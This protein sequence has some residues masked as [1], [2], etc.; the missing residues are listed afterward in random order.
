MATSFSAAALGAEGLAA[1]V[2]HAGRQRLRARPRRLRARP[3]ARATPGVRA[4]FEGRLEAEHAGP[5]DALLLPRRP[6]LHARPTR[7]P[8][9]CSSTDGTI[10][11]LGG[12]DAA[13]AHADGADRGGRPRRR[14]GDPGVRRRPRAPDRRPGS[15]CT[16]STSPAAPSLAEA[17]DAVERRGPRHRRR[18]SLLGHGW[19]ETRWPE[20]PAAHRA[21]SST[22]PPY[23]RRGLPV[24]RRRALRGGLLGARSPPARVRGSRRAATRRGLVAAGGPPRGPRRRS[25]RPSPRPSDGRHRTGRL[26]PRAAAGHRRWSTRAAARTSA[27]PRTSPTCSR[28]AARRAPARGRRLLGRARRRRAR[29]ASRGALG[30]PGRRRPRT[31]TAR[32]ARAP[33]TCATP[34]ADA[35]GRCGHGYLERRA[36][37]RPRR[38]LHAAGL[39]GGFHVIGDAGV[40]DG[41]RRLRGG[42]RAR[43]A[44]RRARG[45]GTGSSTL[46]MV[47]AEGIAR[48]VAPRGSSR[49]CSRR[50]TRY[51]GGADWH[52]RRSGWG[53]SARWP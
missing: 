37:P 42:R 51:W 34:Y 33:R 53:A 23:G 14:A 1:D 45:P 8:P 29:P 40:D 2:T 32:S 7:A 20:Q 50:S 36:G 48:L 31:S 12:D 39:Q 9:P 21:P 16:G 38:G 35:E 25:T 11:W 41:R 43:R 46:E 6:R 27:R 26:R 28:S 30:A 22:G 47:D 13:A 18:R 3:A 15:R 24:P 4:L 10:A 17:L 44:R 5:R 49:A 52:V 19:D